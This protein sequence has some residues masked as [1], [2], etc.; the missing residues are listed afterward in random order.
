MDRWA[1]HF[2]KVLNCSSKVNEEALARILQTDQNAEL[3]ASPD[4]EEV[5]KA[6]NQVSTGKAL[7]ADSIPVEANIKGDLC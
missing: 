6:I 3:D 7:G 4:G 1:E 2:N 5:T